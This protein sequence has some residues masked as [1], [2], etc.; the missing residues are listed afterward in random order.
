VPYEA[1]EKAS[2]Q[3]EALLSVGSISINLILQFI[4]SDHDAVSTEKVI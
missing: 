3:M 2:V 4:F 1:R